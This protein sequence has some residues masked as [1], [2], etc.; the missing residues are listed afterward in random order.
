M[1]R[2]GS[3]LVAESAGLSVD[4][5]RYIVIFT[6]KITLNARSSRTCW[7]LRSLGGCNFHGEVLYKHTQSLPMFD[8]KRAEKE[9][10]ARP[11]RSVSSIFG[12]LSTLV[13]RVSFATRCDPSGWSLW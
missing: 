5:A 12:L 2:S 11:D 7:Y 9:R 10:V 1:T 6:L 4:Q 8:A 3:Q 13:L